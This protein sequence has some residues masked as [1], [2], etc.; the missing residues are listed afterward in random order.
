MR[1]CEK[2]ISNTKQVRKALPR[3]IINSKT[4]KSCSNFKHI[5]VLSVPFPKENGYVFLESSFCCPPRKFEILDARSRRLVCQPQTCEL[6]HG[7]Y[8]TRAI[9]GWYAYMWLIFAFLVN[10]GC[11]YMMAASGLPV[12]PPWWGTFGS[13][14]RGRFFHHKIH[15]KHQDLAQKDGRYNMV[16]LITREMDE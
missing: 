15:I 4:R 14:R 2:P 6:V 12:P 11:I 13:M 10:V 1:R 7:R 9:H 5:L 16:M 3:N 8:Y